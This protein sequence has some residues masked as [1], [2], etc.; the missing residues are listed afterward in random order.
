MPSLR[1]TLE[2]HLAG[3]NEIEVILPRYDLFSDEMAPIE[4]PDGNLEYNV[5]FADCRW[6][7]ALKRARAAIRKVT[8]SQ[9]MPYPVRW[10]INLSIFVL[11]TLSLCCAARRVRRSGFVPDLVY[12]HNQF[13]ALA[14]FLLHCW[15]GIPNVT[16]LYGTFLADLMQKPLVSLRYPTAAAGYIVPS[17]L[18]IC[19]NDGTRGD[20]V[21]RKFGVSAER[22]RFW[23][24]GIDPPAEPPR[25]S[26]HDYLRK[27]GNGIRTESKWIVSCSRLSS[28]K[29]IDRMLHALAGCAKS[30]ADC[31]LLIAGDGPEKKPLQQLA[32]QLGIDE[33]VIWLGAVAH[34]E[35]WGLMNAADIFMITNDVTNR[36]NP[37]FEAIWAGLPVLSVVDP[38]TSDLLVHDENALL[39]ERD[40]NTVLGAHL[41]ALCRDASLAE[42][43]R[44]KQKHQADSF[45]S[46]EERMR[47]EVREL[48]RLV[49]SKG[50]LCP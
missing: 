13:S 5:H 9:S 2:G 45:W 41:A 11:L 35:I 10:M 7:P 39:A 20:M 49:K 23:Q 1:K 50:G 28:W 43:L 15:W 30:G 16:R 22:F 29:R 32:R 31:Q 24:N 40:D 33:R 48:E 26:R 38:S 47:V 34:D 44:L 25:T 46:W 6:L 17:D 42:R 4:V 14:G 36:C 37:L 18:L 21:A 12:A 8:H 3:G 27:F 19:A